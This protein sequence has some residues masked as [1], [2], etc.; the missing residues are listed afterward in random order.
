MMAI[1]AYL[2]CDRVEYIDKVK[3]EEEGDEQG[4]L[5]I[6]CIVCDGVEF[7]DKD[8]EKVDKQGHAQ[9]LQCTLGA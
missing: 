6:P 8:E 7:I 9:I 5:Y 1:H 3:D 4:H 2:R